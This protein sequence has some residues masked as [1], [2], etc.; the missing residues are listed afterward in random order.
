MQKVLD[1]HEDSLAGT[2][3][4]TILPPPIPGA[5]MAQELTP[6][7]RAD[8]DAVLWDFNVFL[9]ERVQSRKLHVYTIA[10]L[11]AALYLRLRLHLH[12]NDAIDFV[13]RVVGAVERHIDDGDLV[14]QF[15]DGTGTMGYHPV[16]DLDADPALREM[17]EGLPVELTDDDLYRF[18]DETE[19]K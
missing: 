18:L 7:Q 4:N 6:E 17:L 8:L 13:N 1:V 5:A 3:Y 12:R 2:L 11:M 16:E 10:D 15:S 14:V 19:S 9:N